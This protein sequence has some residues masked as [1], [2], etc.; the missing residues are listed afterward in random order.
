MGVLA[1]IWHS[2]GNQFVRHDIPRMGK[3]V[4]AV[5][6]GEVSEEVKSFLPFYFKQIQLFFSSGIRGTPRITFVVDK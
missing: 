1:I 4:R 3:L 5:V 2:L 6:C